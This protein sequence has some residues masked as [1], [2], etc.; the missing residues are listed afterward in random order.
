MEVR[1]GM[2]LRDHQSLFA[3]LAPAGCY[4]ALRAGFFAP[5][6]ELNL[7][8]PEWINH[9]TFSGLALADPLLRWCQENSGYA[10]WGEI[11]SFVGTSFMRDYRS[12]GFEFGGVVSIHGTQEMPKR[13]L[14]IFA[15]SDRELRVSE[16]KEIERVLSRIHSDEPEMPTEAQMEALQLYSKGYLHKQVAHELQLSVGGVKAR[17]RGAADRLGAKTLREAASIAASRGLL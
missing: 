8:P 13:S 4:V 10:R 3:D 9:Y 7:F 17:L 16:M 6:A 12:F 15:R 2:I 5:E 1:N 11:D 14:G